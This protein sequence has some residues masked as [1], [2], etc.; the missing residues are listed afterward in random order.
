MTLRHPSVQLDQRR[1]DHR[2]EVVE[3]GA[4]GNERRR[5]HQHG[6]AAVV[7]AS[8][9]AGTAHGVGEYSSAHLDLLR[10]SEL[11]RRV[12]IGRQLEP[13][14]E[15]CA[16]HLLDGSVPERQL[17][18]PGAEVSSSSSTCSGI[19]SSRSAVMLA[20]ATAVETGWPPKVAPCVKV[21][22]G[23]SSRPST[24]GRRTIMP[25]SGA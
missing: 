17:V 24:S 14:E 16:A 12:A 18:Q 19:R 4:I 3:H 15:A 13:V 6:R 25:P 5:E 22:T 7:G 10:G 20:T 1:V 21:A 9:K 23:E 2:E 8:E 11:P